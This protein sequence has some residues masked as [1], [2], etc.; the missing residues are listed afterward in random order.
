[1]SELLKKF[2]DYLKPHLIPLA[3]F[4]GVVILCLWGRALLRQ[5]RSDF[6]QR[7]DTYQKLRD[8]EVKKIIAATEE[9]RALYRE[10]IR[11][12]EETIDTIQKKYLDDMKKLDEAKSAQ[13]NRIVENFDKNPIEAAR[14]ISD[15]TGLKL[16]LPEGQK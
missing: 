7:L 12:Y 3:M 1:M 8:D 4:A 14:Q 15:L 11:K 10:N 6:V 5:E 9:E 16:V 13:V 2:W